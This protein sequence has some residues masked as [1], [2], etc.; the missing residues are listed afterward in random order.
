MS[1][2]RA[3]VVMDLRGNLERQAR[4]Y[5]GAMRQMSTAGQRHIGRLQ[6]VTGGLGRTLDRVGNRWVALATGAAGVGVTR[7]LV[8]LEER[9]SRLGIQ[10]QRSTEDMDAL[11]KMIFE[12]ARDPEIRADPSAITEAIEEIVGR[13]GDLAFAEENIR[14]IGMAISATGV[15]GRDIGGLMAEIQKMG[16]RSADEVLQVIDTFNLQGKEG[17]FALEALASL[18]PRVI[19]AYTAM[20]R[21]GPEAM[22]E[23]GAALQMVMRGIGDRNLAATAF[24]SLL[25][26]F[27]DVEKMRELQRMSGVQIFDPEALKEGREMLR[28]IN[29]LMEELVV[30]ADGR[31]SRLSDFF[32]GP[33]LTAFN[34]AVTEYNLHGEVQS[35]RHYMTLHGDG[36]DTIKDSARAADTAGGALRNLSSAWQSFADDNLT[37]H[38]QSAADALNS[39]DQETVNRWLQ[40]AGIAAGSIGGLYALRSMG[41]LAV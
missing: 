24:Q 12:T 27:Q 4:R 39:L 29:E 17:A 32:T 40:I 7:N 16:I 10:A 6:R 15:A 11:R 9:F 23:M 5:E 13:V 8:A 35:L 21:S 1:E 41:R 20:G 2:L 14:N 38:I 25:A 28:P 26:T 33:A 30:A 34:R 31:M 18:G 36:A 19:N 37:Q 22:R 3:S